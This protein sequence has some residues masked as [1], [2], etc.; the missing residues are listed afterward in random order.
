MPNGKLYIAHKWL[1]GQQPQIRVFDS[2]DIA[3][4]TI[5]KELLE[6]REHSYSLAEWNRDTNEPGDVLIYIPR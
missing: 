2:L 1:S 4:S 6:D 3:V 5:C